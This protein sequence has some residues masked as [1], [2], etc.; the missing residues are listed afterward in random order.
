MIV[1]DGVSCSILF[2]R[3]DKI[4]KKIRTCKI[5]NREQYIN[6]LND[7]SQLHSK[8]I[9]AIDPGKCDLIYC[10][11]NSNKGA[12]KYRYSQD[13]RRKETKSKKYSKIL[14]GQ[15]HTKIGEK[16]ITE[17]ET[18]LSKYNHKTLDIT[19]FKEYCSKKNEMNYHL[20]HFYEKTLFRK[21][22]LNGYWNRLKSEQKMINQFR[23]IFG[24]AK[25]TIVCYG[26]FK[27]R[28]H[29]KFKEPTK[30]KGMRTL[31]RKSGYK[32]YLVDE[33]RT[34]CKCSKCDGG[35]CRKFMF[36]ENP[37]PFRNNIR[38]V[39][40]LLSCKNCANVWNRDCNGASNIYKIA[41]NSIN[42]I[43]RPSYLCR[44]TSGVLD[45]TSNPKL[46]RLE[47]VKL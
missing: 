38:F 28:K 43:E 13:R 2:L 26:D 33:F 25:D 11:D 39:H 22:K 37:K 40:G 10:V 46:T 19:K 23:R 15:K 1:T 34:S 29:M 17:Y 5:P 30:G 9:V 16:N 14:L 41:Y 36:R 35:N 45:D 20:F 4:G 8:K 18:E 6:E 47:T 32:T 21:L 12:N 44:N 24:N 7:Y 27:Q 31:F 3:N 42:K